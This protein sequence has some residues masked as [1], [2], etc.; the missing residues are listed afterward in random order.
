MRPEGAAPTT[1]RFS[2]KV[3]VVLRSDLA[4][5]QKLNSG[6]DVHDDQ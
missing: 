5:W 4:Q 3:A 2:T 6:A 1:V